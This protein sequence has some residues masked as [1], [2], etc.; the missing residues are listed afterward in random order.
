MKRYTIISLLI[1]AFI[2]ILAS[3]GSKSTHHEDI[4]IDGTYV[5]EDAISRSTVII[6][7]D[8]WRMKTQFGAPGY[9]GSDAKY[10]SGT[11]KGKVLY[12]SNLFAYGEVSGRTLRIG[13]RS[14][15][16]Q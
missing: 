5:Y 3:C 4:S 12:H 7:G 13:S 14:Y 10:D 11:V 15:Y 9:Y 6:S 16:K 8:E 2:G 1:L